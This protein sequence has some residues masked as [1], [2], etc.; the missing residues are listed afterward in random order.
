[1]LAY[2]YIG[3]E[4]E[5][6]AICSLEDG[7][8]AIV[9]A[10]K[11][12]FFF[13][14]FLGTAALDARALSIRDFD[15]TRFIRRVRTTPN[16]RFILTT[17][18]PIFEEARRVSDRLGD[19]RLD[20]IKYVLDVGV[21]TRRIKARIFYNHLFVAGTPKEYVKALW[22]ARAIAKI[23]DHKN[24]NPRV[25][26]AMTDDMHI[27]DID[28]KHYAQA[29]LKM[30]DNPKQIW[31]TAF[32]THIPPMCR[33][34]LI[35]LF[36]CSEYGVE[37]DDLKTAFNALHSSLSRKYGTPYGAKDFEEALKIL[38]GGFIAIIGIQ[39]RFI[40]PSVR[41]YLTDYLDDLDLISDC[42]RAATTANWASSV[43]KHVMTT[44]LSHFPEHEVVAK[45]F[46]EVAKS[47]ISLPFWKQDPRSPTTA[48]ICDLSNGG[49]ISLMLEWH[50]WSKDDRFACFAL[51]LAK[52]PF[53]G[54]SAWLDG[55]K[56][57]DLV[58][59]LR[60]DS[61]GDESFP[62]AEEI[63]TALEAS[64]VAL[65]EQGLHADDL[66]KLYAAIDT[67]R[68]VLGENVFEA[69]DG[70]VE[71]E[72]ENAYSN[73]AE[74]DSES[75]LEDQIKALR[76]LASRVSI[77]SERLDSAVFAFESCISEIK[78]RV[79]T[80]EPPSFTGRTPR[81]TDTFDDAA[82]RNLFEPLTRV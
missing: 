73:A 80:T 10:K 41:D 33:H 27:H 55:E 62:Q 68:K 8:G 36:F 7:F 63:A 17:R 66:E 72:I 2:A 23:V 18:A 65:F 16:A 28:P 1:M 59:S 26:E 45:C 69:A 60:D 39:A 6:V 22:D 78:E 47:F 15:L 5:F 42:A 61:D 67:A 19:P 9:D 43:W 14:D 57:V 50:A 30:L 37:I 21:Y 35:A 12:I 34:L 40:N 32:R 58:R 64:L 49:R 70:A 11:Q 20:I 38:E 48:R 81:E 82:L 74:I 76:S 29:F 31:D 54:F 44:R 51:A 24:Y 52:K 3:E 79:S 56:L 71:Q 53:G 77:S 25:I 75:T 4:W 13:D 46:I